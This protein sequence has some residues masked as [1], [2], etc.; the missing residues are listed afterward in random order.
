MRAKAHLLHDEVPV[1]SF[2]WSGTIAAGLGVP[3]RADSHCKFSGAPNIL[4]VPLCCLLCA[5][6]HDFYT[7]R[8]RTLSLSSSACLPACRQPLIAV[9]AD[10]TV[11]PHATMQTSRDLG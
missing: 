4:R 9:R 11:A 8:M 3:P 6:Q 5:F 1:L 7:S 2:T 10:C